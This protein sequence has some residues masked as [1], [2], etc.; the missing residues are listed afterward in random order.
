MYVKANGRVS[1]SLHRESTDYLIQ[2]HLH[3]WLGLMTSE[4]KGLMK[5][6]S[7]GE[8][9]SI[10]QL[11]YIM[12]IDF[13][14]VTC[15]IMVNLFVLHGCGPYYMSGLSVKQEVKRLPKNYIPT[16]HI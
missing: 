5:K 10:H 12:C 9:I 14:A 11:L 16:P 2:V 15:I 4:P 13:V 6:S 7:Q 8:L 1:A 3:S